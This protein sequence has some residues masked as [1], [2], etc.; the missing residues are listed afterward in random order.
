MKG[1][2]WQEKWAAGKIG[3]HQERVNKRLAEHW[4]ALDV[5]PGAVVFVP[6]C[7]KSLDM[8]W[9]HGRAHPV[10]GV[11]LVE[12]A[13]LA[14]F[15]ENALPYERR[16]DGAFERFSGT[17][18]AAGIELLVGD[19]FALTADDLDGV[20]ALYDRASL[21][22]MDDAFRARYARQLAAIVPRGTDGLLLAID[23]EQARMAG[24]PFAVPDAVVQDLL[25]EPFDIETLAH[26]SGPER[27]GNLAGRGL[28]TLDE[29]VYRLRRR[30]G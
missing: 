7:G 27:L 1:S 30:A 14:F 18:A 21:I 25:G 11:E 15:E 9:L 12:A 4:D 26:Y 2:Y 22:A 8:L 5:A 13:V 20:G 17:G 16:A 28:E 19:F 29:R 23:Y 10:L 24:P 3:F 6:L